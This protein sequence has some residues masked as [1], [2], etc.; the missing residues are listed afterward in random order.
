MGLFDRFKANPSQGA[1]HIDDQRMAAD[2]WAFGR[3]YILRSLGRSIP[4]SVAIRCNTLEYEYF[5]LAREDR[6]GL[7]ARARG[8]AEAAGGWTAVGAAQLMRSVT[9]EL[10]GADFDAIMEVSTAFLNSRMIPSAYRAPWELA[11]WQDH[12]P[13]E[14][15][16]SVARRVPTRAS[17]AIPELG[18][19]EARRVANM[20]PDG[21]NNDLYVIRTADQYHCV[22]VAPGVRWQDVTFMWFSYPDLY[23]LYVRVGEAVKS[24]PPWCEPELARYCPID[25]PDFGE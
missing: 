25:P 12:H 21:N 7:L 3:Q 10:N 14:Y 9:T 6:A 17:A 24:P 15:F 23:D 16:F 5:Q 22:I 20:G 19:G 13:G 2:F 1:G 4:E 8:V 18:L 11:W